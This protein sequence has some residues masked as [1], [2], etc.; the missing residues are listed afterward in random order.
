[1]DHSGHLPERCL[2]G[3]WDGTDLLITETE[4][5]SEEK[6]EMA[7]QPEALFSSDP[8]AAATV[9]EEVL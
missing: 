7:L 8:S 3:T 2:P 5:R 4:I 9:P 1:M 6:R